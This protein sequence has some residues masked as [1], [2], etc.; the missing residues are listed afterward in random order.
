[1]KRLCEQ[2]VEI[3]EKYNKRKTVYAKAMLIESELNKHSGVLHQFFEK[4]DAPLIHMGSDGKAGW[5]MRI[6]EE[7]GYFFISVLSR[8]CMGM[9]SFKARLRETEHSKSLPIH[10]FFDPEKCLEGSILYLLEKIKADQ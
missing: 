6:E 3:A 9:C 10:I 8:D 1:M 2:L 7:N 5:Y 4:M